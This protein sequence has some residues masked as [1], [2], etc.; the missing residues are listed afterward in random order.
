MSENNEIEDSNKIKRDVEM[1]L[2]FVNNQKMS[3]LRNESKIRY[4]SGKKSGELTENAVNARTEYVKECAKSFETFYYR[5]T[6]LFYLIID[7]P[8]T[9]TN[10]GKNMQKLNKFFELKNRVEVTKDITYNQVSEQIGKEQYDKYVKP[11]VDKLDK[12]PTF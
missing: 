5:Y 10:N 6:S 9:F 11:V 12:P 7:E 2:N 1:L 3:D 4:T 8:E